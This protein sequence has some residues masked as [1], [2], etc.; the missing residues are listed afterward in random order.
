MKREINLI[1][2]EN[3]YCVADYFT[4]GRCTADDDGECEQEDCAFYHR[5]YP[6]PEQFKEEY[7]EE[8]PEDGAVWIYDLVTHESTIA[9]LGRYKA[10]L[11]E[12]NESGDTVNKHIILCAC[13]PWGK[14]PTDWRPE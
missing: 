7:A 6:T 12:L 3:F 2:C 10:K 9:T 1:G 4:N 8:Y 5:K 14:P 11:R 13:T